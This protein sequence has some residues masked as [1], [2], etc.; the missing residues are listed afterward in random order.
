MIDKPN[1]L[2]AATICF[3]AYF[4]NDCIPYSQNLFHS[5]IAIFF[6]S[7]LIMKE[8]QLADKMQKT[9]IKQSFSF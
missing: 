6:S 1:V 3:A 2:Q 4:A 9:L 7:L 5:G 8:K